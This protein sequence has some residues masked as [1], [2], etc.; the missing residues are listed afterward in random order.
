MPGAEIVIITQG[1][2]GNR[3]TATPGIGYP[4]GIGD[5][6]ENE[7]DATGEVAFTNNAMQTE[8]IFVPAGDKRTFTE[9]GAVVVKP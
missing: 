7:G 2:G 9:A 6:V 1:G 3:T 5:A 4:V 8:D